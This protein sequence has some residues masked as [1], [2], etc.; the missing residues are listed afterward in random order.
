MKNPAVS[1]Y[2]GIDDE[3]DWL[4]AGKGGLSLL[5]INDRAAYDFNLNYVIEQLEDFLNGESPSDKS[6][7]RGCCR[8][9]NAMGSDNRFNRNE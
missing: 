5:K 7:R 6:S 8:S 3:G 2:E 9:R 1:A 4:Y